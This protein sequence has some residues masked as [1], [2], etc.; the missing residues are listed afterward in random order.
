MFIVF[1]FTVK[2]CHQRL[3]ITVPHAKDEIEVFSFE[4]GAFASA[5]HLVFLSF[6]M[7]L[8]AQCQRS[9]FEFHDRVSMKAFMKAAATC[10]TMALPAP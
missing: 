4:N 1:W 8:A 3:P 2:A 9:T 7:R 10:G 6:R 5:A